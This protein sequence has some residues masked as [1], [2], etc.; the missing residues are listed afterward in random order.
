MANGAFNVGAVVAEIKAD[1]TNFKQGISEAKQHTSSLKNAISQT[2]E[3]IADF[4][5]KAAVFTGVVAAGIGVA[6]KFALDG[7]AKF[8]QYQIAFTTLL[9]DEAKAAAALKAIQEDAAKTPFELAPLVAANQRL[10][11]AGVSAQDARKQIINL[12]NAI[13]ATG[14]GSAELERLSTNLQQIKAVGKASALDIKQFAFAGINVYQ[15]LADATGKNVEQ[16]RDMDVSYELL[17]QAFEKASAKGGLFE[18]AMQKQSQS[19]NGLMS[20]LKDTLSLGL[21]DI[22]VGTGAFDALRNSIAQLIPMLQAG[23][24]A[25]INF[26][27]GVK[28][29]EE[30]QAFFSQLVDVFTR[31]SDWVMANQE[32]VLT[33]LQGLGIALGV[34]L[35]VGTITA[36]LT[37]LLNPITLVALGVAAL[38]TAWQTNFM[39]IRDITQKVITFIID[40]FNT[41]FKPMFE[42]FVAWWTERWDFIKIGLMGTWEIIKG[43]IMVAWGLIYGFITTALAIMQGDWGRAWNQIKKSAEIVWDGLRNLFAGIINF[44]IGWG[45]TVF[46]KLYEPFENAWKKISETVEKI[47][48]ALDFTKRHSPSIMDIINK[49]VRLAN[50]AFGKLDFNTNITTRAAEPAFIGASASTAP[51]LGSVI[52]NLD[53]ALIANDAA[54]LDIGEMIGDQ[55]IKKLNLSIRS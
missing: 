26:V 3:T 50:D 43:I 8:E 53:G 32:L 12:G 47:K 2:G 20:T 46:H 55:I 45:G 30:V 17:S 19:L 22:L 52:V 13:S 11:S 34:L 38:F 37:A 14:G 33:F 7:A 25:V 54:A 16:V 48:E 31:I 27:K 10:I 35:I 15:L 39:G 36:L 40:L 1:L 18:G 5:K 4:G 42:L 29:S 21:K 24:D 49:G 41:V 6:S 9:K 51:G 28:Q 23:V 44:I